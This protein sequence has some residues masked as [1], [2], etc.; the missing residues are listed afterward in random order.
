MKKKAKDTNVDNYNPYEVDKLSKI[1]SWIK[2]LLLKF[3]AAAAAVFFTMIGGIDVGLDFSLLDDSTVEGAIG[4]SEKIIV[5]L[6]FTMALMSNYVIKQ[7]I[8][9]MNNRRNNAFKY[10][11]IN[12]RGFLPLFYYLIY[13]FIVSLILYFIT[14]WLGSNGLV[15]DPFGVAGNAGLEPFTYGL[16]YVIVDGFFVLIKNLIVNIYQRVQYKRQLAMN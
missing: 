8:Y 16:C 2:I 4:N 7:L 13:S 14:L 12:Q 9:L 10:N 1:P 6:G 3:W 11:M 5:I 15:L